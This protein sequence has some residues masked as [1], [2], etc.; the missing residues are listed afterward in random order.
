LSHN[1]IVK[2]NNDYSIMVRTT[3]EGDLWLNPGEYLQYAGQE[4]MMPTLTQTERLEVWHMEIGV[5][6]WDYYD[7]KPHT[8]VDWQKEGF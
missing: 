4:N 1:Y 3:N 5:A 2:N 6:D 8:P 7:G